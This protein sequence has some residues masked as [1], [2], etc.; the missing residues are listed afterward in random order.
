M[1]ATAV[2]Q[3]KGK[4]GHRDKLGLRTQLSAS[5]CVQQEAFRRASNSD[6]KERPG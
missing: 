2:S 4:G 1:Q 3:E 6:E 5:C